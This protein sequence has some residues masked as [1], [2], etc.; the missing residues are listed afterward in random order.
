MQY[1]NVR[2]TSNIQVSGTD[3]NSRDESEYMHA[4]RAYTTSL[5]T[6]RHMLTQIHT[7][8]DLLLAIPHIC[9]I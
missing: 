1:L 5:N 7:H 3:P 8:T 9:I 4:K 2:I 6:Y